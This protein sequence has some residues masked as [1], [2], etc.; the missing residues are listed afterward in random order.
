MMCSVAALIYLLFP[1]PSCCGHMVT[2]LLMTSLFSKQDKK[3]IL[4]RKMLQEVTNEYSQLVYGRTVWLV[5]HGRILLKKFK[6][7]IF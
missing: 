3:E 6:L 7:T 2:L 4:A 1:L 5:R